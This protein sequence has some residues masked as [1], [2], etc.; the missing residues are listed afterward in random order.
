MGVAELGKPFYAR[1]PHLQQNCTYYE[2]R[3]EGCRKWRCAW[4]M[5]YV[6]DKPE[7]RPDKLGLVIHFNSDGRGTVLEVYEAIPGALETGRDRVRH[8]VNRIRSHRSLKRVVYDRIS[9][10]FYPYGSDIPIN[11]AVSELYAPYA[12]REERPLQSDLPRG[13]ATFSGARHE[14]LMP[15]KPAQQPGALG[16]V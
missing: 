10:I 15:A 7:W 8:I 14:L 6:G 2:H 4:H 3:P 12:T 16:T 5:G 11:F 9:L 13:E 1:C